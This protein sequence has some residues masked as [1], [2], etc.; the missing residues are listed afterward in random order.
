MTSASEA[1]LL[2]EIGTEELPPKSL[3]ELASAFA[4]GI[5]AGLA[6]RDIAADIAAAKMYCSPRRLAVLVPHVAKMQ[7]D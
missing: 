4:S 7:P 5:T 2:I 6:K 3:D 1:S